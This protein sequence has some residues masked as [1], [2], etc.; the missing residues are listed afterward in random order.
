ME[1]VSGHNE[2]LN[3]A[4]YILIYLVVLGHFIAPIIQ[5]DT[6]LRTLYLFIYS[7]HMPAFVMISGMLS[8]KEPNRNTQRILIK[9]LLIPFAL[10]TIIYELNHLL[11]FKAPSDYLLN[12]IP[13]WVLWYLISLY[14]WRVTLAKL[15]KVKAILYLSLI[16]S[17]AFGLIADFGNTYGLS[18]T[19]YFW[20]FFLIGHFLG[21]D[22]HKYYVFK[23][24]LKPYWVIAL[25]LTITALYFHNEL[26]RFLFYGSK[27]YAQLGLSQTDGFISRGVI[28]LFSLLN[29]LAILTLVPNKLSIPTHW[30][31]NSLYIYLWHGIIIKIFMA[32]GVITLIG[33]T[34]HIIRYGLILTIS[35]II[36]V[37][38]ATNFIAVKTE[39]Y[40]FEPFRK[41][42]G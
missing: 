42:I 33:N 15:V 22:F 19:I 28:Y 11:L 23:P 37:I 16:A 25:A 18:R 27:S 35:I 10:F 13:H 26:N 12:L 2:K 40:L 9:K 39:K 41:I 30:K 8:S 36:T 6:A 7:F 3:N 29:A 17:L 4:K 38:L 32:A 14:I 5:S 24:T 34:D 20:P 21:K 1:T 31:T